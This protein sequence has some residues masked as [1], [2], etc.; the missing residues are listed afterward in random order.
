[1]FSDNDLQN[2]KSHAN[3][4]LR[5]DTIRKKGVRLADA[6]KWTQ[7]PSIIWPVDPAHYKMWREVARLKRNSSVT[8]PVQT[9][10]FLKDDQDKLFYDRD[11]FWI[12]NDD[13]TL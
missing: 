10:R 12:K 1:M 6:G 4:T 8:A 2:V 7:A 3:R 13:V 11:Y 5:K 9:T